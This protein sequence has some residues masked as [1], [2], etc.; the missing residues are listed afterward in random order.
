MTDRE[1]PSRR[2]LR[3]LQRIWT[4]DPVFFVTVC[5]VGRQAVLVPTFA[6]VLALGLREASQ[7]HHWHVGRYVVMPD[8]L[9]FFCAP[10]ADAGTLS[11][12]VGGFKQLSTRR[13]WEAG[14][15]GKLWQT[16]FFDHLL[17]SEESYGSKWEY[18]RRNPVRGGICREPEDWPHQG[19]I[20]IL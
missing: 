14:W 7:R 20:V 8:H 18:V 16:E 15:T 13:A 11:D 3:R 17:R 6:P 19:E 10:D 9:H 12:F 1:L 2:H 5:A 4:E